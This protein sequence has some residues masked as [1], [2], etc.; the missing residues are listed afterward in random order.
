MEILR[1]KRKCQKSKTAVRKMKDAL[2][3]TAVDAAG[4][5]K[6]SVNLTIGQY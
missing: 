2:V 3:G 4:P 1:V 6:A 5:G